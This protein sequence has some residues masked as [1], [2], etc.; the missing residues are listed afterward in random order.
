M[1]PHICTPRI[2]KLILIVALMSSCCELKPSPSKIN[3]CQSVFRCSH[4]ASMCPALRRSGCNWHTLVFTRAVK[5][6]SNQELRH[7]LITSQAIDMACFQRV[8]RVHAVIT[9]TNYLTSV[10]LFQ[11]A[12]RSFPCAMTPSRYE[13]ASRIGANSSNS[14]SLVVTIPSG[15]LEDS[16]ETASPPG[17][18]PTQATGFSSPP[19]AFSLYRRPLN[20]DESPLATISRSP[21]SSGGATRGLSA[22]VPRSCAVANGATLEIPSSAKEVASGDCGERSTIVYNQVCCPLFILLVCQSQ[23]ML[24]GDALNGM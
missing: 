7:W 14:R 8:A 16:E 13:L 24:E 23:N 17:F 3:A 5:P 4:G 18:P 11:V 21:S 1:G 19:S 10:L 9:T 20:R 12:E 6:V 15:D 22:V 2:N